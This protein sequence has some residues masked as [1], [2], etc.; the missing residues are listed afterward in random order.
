M[1]DVLIGRQAIYDKGLRVR[2]YELLFRGG[3]LDLSRPDQA[4][5]ATSRVLIDSLTAIGLERLVGDRP[6]FINLTRS[7]VLGE[8]PLPVQPGR[9]VLEVL[10]NVGIDEPIVAGLRRLKS[11]GFKLALDDFEYEPGCE[12]LLELADLVKLDVLTVDDAEVE[13]RLELL[14]PYKLK[15]LAEKIETRERFELCKRLGF[16]LFQGY[17]L[18]RPSEVR[19]R[20]LAPNQLVLLQLLATLHDPA[21]EF[22]RAEEIVCSDVALSYRLLRHV[23]SARFSLPRKVESIRDTLVYLGLETVKGM[24]LLFLMSAMENQPH[25]LIQIAM[26]RAK[27]C[28]LL[29]KA[30]AADDVHSFFTVGLLSTLDALMNAPMEDLLAELPLADELRSALLELDG[31]LGAVLAATLAY[32]RGEWDGVG[33]AGLGADKVREAFLEALAWAREMEQDLCAPAGAPGAA[34]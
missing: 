20:S 28:Q 3:G 32:E 6:A 31:E 30:R 15:T 33:K 2:A 22:D 8:Y 9:V 11:Q 27:M 19:E 21:L 24:A 10:E 26:L 25:D 17:F 5:R 13:R 1:K 12:P 34:T 23:N 14:R 7:F 4:D 29:A 18:A 16:D